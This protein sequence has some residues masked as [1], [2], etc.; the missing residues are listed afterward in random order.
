MRPPL[1]GAHRPAC[2]DSPD[3]LFCSDTATVAPRAYF[4]CLA[5]KSRQ[6]EAPGDALYC[7]LPRAF[8]AAP[9][10]E[11]PLRAQDCNRSD[12]FQ[13]RQMYYTQLRI[14]SS[15]FRF[16]SF[17]EYST[18]GPMRASAPTNV[19]KTMFGR[20]ILSALSNIVHHWR[21]RRGAVISTAACFAILLRGNCYRW[22]RCPHAGGAVVQ[23]CREIPVCWP[24]R[25]STGYFCGTAVQSDSF[26]APLFAHFF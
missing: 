11:R 19:S 24:Q 23:L 13:F 5:R 18:G 2:P 25:S 1:A 22:E 15:R 9:R 16:C 10:P 3:C 17:P 4:F 21:I 20:T 6:K 8:L 26:P 7:A 14:D 12:S